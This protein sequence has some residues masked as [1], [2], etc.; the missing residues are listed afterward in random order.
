MALLM[1]QPGGAKIQAT[2]IVQVYGK[3]RAQHKVISDISL[4]I[5]D[6]E[7]VIIYGPS[8][9]GKTTLLNIISGLEAPTEGEVV[10]RG[11]NLT[12]LSNDLRAQF[13]AT[14][15]GIVY[16]QAQWIRALNVIENVALPLTAVGYDRRYAEKKA[17]Q[18]LKQLQLGHLARLEPTE[19][20]GGEQQRVNLARAMVHQPDIM[21]ADEPT[22][23]LDSHNSDEVMSLLSNLNKEHQITILLVTHNLIYLPYATHT[24]EMK[25]GKIIKN[26]VK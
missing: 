3:E 15:M 10:I 23:N 4:A 14:N 24:I 11:K 19:L 20:S 12:K 8:G 7:F 16:Q 5:K 17:L 6:G 2:N 9:C 1:E 25:D 21:I 22:G 18:I 13:R 26:E